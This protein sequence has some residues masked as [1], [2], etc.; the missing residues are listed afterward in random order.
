MCSQPLPERVVDLQ[1]SPPPKT[2]SQIR[3]FLGM[4][5]FYRRFLPNAAT[6]QVPLHDVKGC[7]PVNWTDAAFNEG[8]ASL[9]LAAVLAHP[10]PNAPLALVTDA[11]TTAMDA[12]LQQRMQG[13]GLLN[14]LCTQ[15]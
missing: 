15:Y 2:V 5:N 10:H 13:V 12:V 3:R 6:I 8:K 11:L 1:V 9:S 14:C 4:L 7:H